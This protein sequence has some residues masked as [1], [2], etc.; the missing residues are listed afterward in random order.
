MNLSGTIFHDLRYGVRMLRR[1]LGFTAVAVLALGLGIG[2]NT[3]VFT[4]YKTMVARPLQ[5]RD[6]GDMVNL[7]LR[8][9]SGSVENRFSY[10]EY[11]TYRDSLHSFRGLIAT[12]IEQLRL[13]DAGGIVSERTSAAESG[14]GRLGL[15]PS[16]ASNAEFTSVLA[17]SENYFGV[18]GVAPLRGRSFDSMPVSALLASP[19]ILIS[20]NYWR[21][22][23]AGDPSVL[24]KT[25]RL[26]GIAV[27]IIGITPHDF[28][29]THIAVPDF[30]L[31][32]S[33]EP[34][35]HA[36]PNWLRDRERASLQMFGRLAPEI[37]IAQA[38][39]EMNLVAARLRTLHDPK[40]EAAKP[41]TALIWPGSP[42]PFPLKAYGWLNYAVML[43]MVAAGMVLVVACAD[44]GSLQLAR[45]R[46][47]EHEFETRLALGA[48]RRRIIR[49][50]LTESTLLGL[51]A[52]AV[53][54]PVTSAVLNFG[55]GLAAEAFPAQFGTV[56]F[57][58]TPDATIFLYVF[59]IS[60]IAAI[61]FGLVPALE[62]SRSAPSSGARGSTS[63][64][65]SRRIQNFLIAAQV[66]L[67]LVLMIVGS[68]FIR[69]SIN[70][71]K[72]ETGYDSKHVLDIEL[73]FPEGSK[74]I[75]SR[76]LALV[77]ELRLRLAA[78]PG[79]VEV[80]SAKPPGGYSFMT[81]VA[82]ADGQKLKESVPPIHYSFVQADYFKTLGIPLL[83]G[84][85]FQ[86]QA[87]RAALSIVLS[88]SLARQLWPGANPIGRSIRLGPIDEKVHSPSEL[89]PDGPAYQVVGIARDTR[90]LD[91]SGRDTR[92]MYLPLP[93]ARL[94]DY[95]ILI[96]TT[97]DPALVTRAVDSTISSVDPDIA[98]NYVSLDEL[99]R[100]S[101]AFL[102]STL[103]AAIASTIGILGL[104]LAS[105]GIFGTVNYVVLL[106]TREV[107][108]RMAVG[109]ARSDVLR[110]I[111]SDTTRP[112]I[113]GLLSGMILAVGATDLLHGILYGLNSV[114]A[115]SFVGVPLLFL[116]IAL[117]AAY[118]PA[119]RATR[120]DPGIALKYD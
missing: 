95:P 20:E 102:T 113:A 11:E 100:Q 120:I 88:E 69:S 73:Q 8:R 66:S 101:P 48:S 70:S 33:L 67:S 43:I 63:P 68:M 2:V 30:W 24:G 58:V 13:S 96:R 52:G 112:V 22:R 118:P 45:S 93:E 18:L 86:A 105:M 17:V 109:A 31:P 1:N 82:T 36:D 28:F 54:L 75:G 29:G 35:I 81:A 78:L 15:L 62:S 76:R 117:V 59:G 21:K 51:L 116:T 37:G 3:A 9:D 16:G 94:E 80:T 103:G 89:H 47:R 14:L 108:I 115:I 32:L 4:A 53:A 83:L 64:V 97:S 41:A 39:S 55:V 34:L 61:L 84:S 57:D 27:T 5:A 56:I 49:Q 12:K 111:L 104:L 6:P 25:I 119:R 92:R 110:L 107:G 87:N 71:L 26:N 98:A 74:Y 60:L 10:P 72:M 38:Q 77:K 65:R 23:F 19:S 90:A 40:T 114:D 99:L 85:S 106:R 50:L 42:F 91:L 44:V 79:V 46:F 7:A